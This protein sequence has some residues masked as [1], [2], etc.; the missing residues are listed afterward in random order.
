MTS[1]PTYLRDHGGLY[2]K[3]PRQAALR[4]FRDAKYHL[5]LHYGPYSLPG[6]REWVQQ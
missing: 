6:R 1:V 2:Q 3:D 5:S 4:W